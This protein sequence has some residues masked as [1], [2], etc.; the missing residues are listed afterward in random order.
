VSGRSGRVQKISSPPAFDPKTVQS[1]ASR[2]SDCAVPAH[3]DTNMLF[4]LIKCSLL[5]LGLA[6]THSFEVIFL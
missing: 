2:Y 5:L 1:V 4:K 6:E 3:F